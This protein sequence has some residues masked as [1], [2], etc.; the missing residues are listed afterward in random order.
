MSA[1]KLNEVLILGVKG[2]GKTVFL[3][4]LGHKY[5][6][7][8]EFGLSL[9]PDRETRR[10]ANKYYHEMSAEDGTEQRFPSVTDK[11][12][13]ALPLTWTVKAGT[14]QL[15][16]M[17][18]LEC[19]GETMAEAFGGAG[20]ADAEK[21]YSEALT[22]AFDAIDADTA[23]GV[24]VPAETRTKLRVM[25]KRA[26]LVCLFLNPR[27]FEHQLN[28]LP[29]RY[30]ERLE[31]RLERMRKRGAGEKELAEAREASQKR[32][33][34]AREGLKNRY[35]SMLDLVQTFLENPEYRTKRLLFVLTQSG[36]LGRAIE[37]AGGAWG[38]LT[39]NVRQLEAYDLRE[40]AEAIAVSAVNGVALV[41]EKDGEE[42]ERPD[43][44]IQP[45]GM[46]DFLLMV[47]GECTSRMEEL[48]AARVRCQEAEWR[49][50]EALREWGSPEE[51]LEAAR[52]WRRAGLDWMRATEH[53]L[54]GLGYVPTRVKQRTRA[55][56]EV[57]AARA[58]RR[59]AA[60]QAMWSWLSEGVAEGKELQ[61]ADLAGWL[62][63]AN[64]SAERLKAE[65]WTR[66]ELGL[67]EGWLAEAVARREKEWQGTKRRFETAL[68][69]LEWE[70][71]RRELGAAG[72]DPEGETYRKMSRQC[73]RVRLERAEKECRAALEAEDAAEAAVKLGELRE[74]EAEAGGSA[75]RGELE[76][77]LACLR[78]R[79]E[80][81]KELA[82][83]LK[84]QAVLKTG[85][86]RKVVAVEAGR[87]AWPEA[88]KALHAGEKEFGAEAFKDLRGHYE[89]WQ[90]WVAKLEAEIAGA[91]HRKRV[92]VAVAVAVVL[93]AWGVMRWQEAWR[94]RGTTRQAMEQ[95]RLGDYAGAKEMLG[96]VSNHPLLL[97]WRNT[98]APKGMEERLDG[99]MGMDRARAG[100]ENKKAEWEKRCEALKGK[101]GEK[102]WEEAGGRA[103]AE[104]LRLAGAI[105]PQLP[106]AGAG[107]RPADLGAIS[108]ATEAYGKAAEN[109]GQATA[110][111]EEAEKGA[112]AMEV[113]Y[114]KARD[115][116][117]R[118]RNERTKRVN[119]L[120]GKCPELEKLGE[121]KVWTNAV[122]NAKAAL[123]ELKVGEVAMPRDGGIANTIAKYQDAM[124]SESEEAAAGRALDRLE[125]AVEGKL[126]ETGA[127]EAADG[128]G[129][130]D[131]TAAAAAAG[132]LTAGALP[133]VADL[134]AEW[135]AVMKAGGTRR[136]I[137]KEEWED[138]DRLLGTMLENPSISQDSKEYAEPR[139]AVCDAALVYFAEKERRQAFGKEEE[140][141]NAAM[142]KQDWSS[143]AKAVAWLERN[144]RGDAEKA[145]IEKL[146]GEVDN[147][148]Q[149]A[150]EG[151]FGPGTEYGDLMEKLKALGILEAETGDGVAEAIEK[152]LDRRYTLTPPS[153]FPASYRRDEKALEQ[154]G[155]E[156]KQAELA[157]RCKK[158]ENLRRKMANR[159]AKWNAEWLKTAEA[160]KDEAVQRAENPKTLGAAWQLCRKVEDAS[161]AVKENREASEEEKKRADTIKGDLPSL[162][163]V[164]ADQDIAE[165]RVIKGGKSEKYERSA[166]VRGETVGEAHAV[167]ILAGDKTGKMATVEVQS[168]TGAKV[169]EPMQFPVKGGTTTE[170]V[171]F[172]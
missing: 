110:K 95:V 160:D 106:E 11:W 140:R 5:E 32:L 127:R 31:S 63:T 137:P 37:E 53:F 75:V 112:K 158:V 97:L 123:P 119:E 94:M 138:L 153:R 69:Q 59:Y 17:T 22:E 147:E 171:S 88:G 114:K 67:E 20:D 157:Q 166:I 10:F 131:W 9:S 125:K 156:L 73:A 14:E 144:A 55:F 100:L 85:S 116:V 92:G 16:R 148:V 65:A 82:K 98:Y 81:Q 45:T 46:E 48:K 111:L 129:I 162:L 154:L 57:D 61:T 50:T 120:R 152:T 86:C 70:K 54:E 6:G 126:S 76:R 128:T 96:R 23:T 83:L 121:W 7:V 79:L 28:A 159:V 60:E 89:K 1:E 4:V 44:P 146:R 115:A 90:E 64:A 151:A 170:T 71:A 43:G 25:A 135:K 168:S 132:R 124:R 29:G 3:S 103:W 56:A 149:T 13:D 164:R 87:R 72:L 150:V 102:T 104:S 30:E 133:D 155:K 68:A 139:K 122:H 84:I 108:R 101:Y 77:G 141:A 38:Y 99:A 167:A 80:V 49:F 117:V 27:D 107:G 62:A 2:S 26:T 93:C 118:V 66:D 8:G 172:K 40:R 47:G 51:R 143:A 161:T 169:K 12:A 52:V 113:E 35:L 105:Q 134:D 74:A 136:A 41:E 42:R 142:R 78:A 36:E 91:L 34:E 145:R 58:E 18:T 24:N 163:C 33:Q 21:K 19:A 130:G 15:F 39:A 109:F 165:V